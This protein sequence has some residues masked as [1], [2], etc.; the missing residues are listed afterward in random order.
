MSGLL[1]CGKRSINP[2]LIKESG[3]N[4]YSIEEL[5][6]YIYNNTYMIGREFF[7]EELAEYVKVELELPSL[8]QKLKYGIVHNSDILTMVSDILMASNYYSV[9]ERE[10]IINTLKA[11]SSKSKSERMKARADMLLERKKYISAA[12]AYKDILN[13]NDEVYSTEFVATVWN[14]IG[15]TY[16]KQF[17]FEDACRCFKTACDINRQED[18]FDNMVCAAIFSAN[19]NFIEDIVAQYQITEAMMDQYLKAIES[20][21]KMLVKSKE[22]SE[23]KERLLYDGSKEYSEYKKDVQKIFALWKEEYRLENM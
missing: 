20:N 19:D 15:I 21:K 8:A 23:L 1:L 17:L 6:Y 9:E 12:N 4:I 7:C 11:L 2:Y 3:I 10:N 22:F 13:V 14:N 18:Y 16:T 5:C